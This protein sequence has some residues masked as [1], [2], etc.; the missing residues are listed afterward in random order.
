MLRLKS[1][2]EM[3]R[4]LGQKMAPEHGPCPRAGL[5]NTFHTKSPQPDLPVGVKGNRRSAL[6]TNG[7]PAAAHP[8]SDLTLR[9]TVWVHLGSLRGH[10]SAG[11]ACGPNAQVLS[12]VAAPTSLGP[13]D[14]D[15]QMLWPPHVRLR[16]QIGKTFNGRLGDRAPRKLLPPRGRVCHQG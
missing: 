12:G 1:C 13:A 10:C 15:V 3:P 9:Q 14:G 16:K 2:I 4:A 5:E 11:G 6:A 8:P 7:R